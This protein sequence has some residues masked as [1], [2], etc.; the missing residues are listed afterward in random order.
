MFFLRASLMLEPM[1]GYDA[2]N[3]LLYHTFRGYKAF[4]RGVQALDISKEGVLANNPWHS[5]SVIFRLVY[6]NGPLTRGEMLRCHYNTYL[7][8]NIRFSKNMDTL[9]DSYE[10]SFN[11]QLKKARDEYKIIR[12]LDVKLFKELTAET[13]EGY[14]SRIENYQKAVRYPTYPYPE[15]RYLKL[16]SN[17]NHIIYI[18]NK[19]EYVQK[20]TMDMLDAFNSIKNGFEGGMV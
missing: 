2:L 5:V 9:N 14:V 18:P 3:T 8:S 19:D 7:Q 1:V 10:K 6:T 17:K 11:N 13:W 16:I 4:Y 15:E 20:F 12:A